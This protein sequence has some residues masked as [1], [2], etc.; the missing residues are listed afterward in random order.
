MQ[1]PTFRASP[2]ASGKASPEP[3]RPSSRTYL[4]S[5]GAAGAAA[6]AAVSL[7]GCGL[8]GGSWDVKLEV[9]GAGAA[10]ISYSFSGDNDGKTAAGQQLP[11]SKAQNVGFG[12]ND[13]GIKDA[14]PGTAC[15]IYVDGKLKDE[16][17][18]PD[19]KGIVSCSIH[20]QN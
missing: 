2:E 16:Q 4:R 15:R 9:T 18:E 5:L 3:S 7:T 11:W 1:F 6:V 17:K 14:P 13:L 20:L 8:F 10:D 12:F 19:D